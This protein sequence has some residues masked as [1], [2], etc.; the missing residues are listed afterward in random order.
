MNQKRL[1]LKA[2]RLPFQSPN[3]TTATGDFEANTIVTS[4]QESLFGPAAVKA[5]VLANDDRDR[6]G[7]DNLRHSLASFLVRPKTDTKTLQ[8]LLR[9]SHVKTTLQLCAH[10]V[11]EDRLAAQ[12]YSRHPGGSIPPYFV[13][14]D[15]R[16]ESADCI[17]ARFKRPRDAVSGH[18]DEEP[19]PTRKIRH[20]LSVRNSACP[21]ETR[22][23]KLASVSSGFSSV[24]NS[25]SQ[26]PRLPLFA[27]DLLRSRM[28]ELDTIRGVAIL[29]VLFFHGFGFRYGLEGVSGFPRLFVAATLPGWVGVNLFFVLSGFLITG[30]LLDTL[31][32]ANYYRSFYVRR[33]LRILPLYYAVLLLLAVLTRTGWV[34]RH[35]SWAFLGLSFFYLSNVTGL[36]GVPMQYGVLWSLAVEE[37]FYL[38]WPAAVRSLSRHRVAIVGAIICVLCPSLRAFYSIRGYETG[39]GYTW[40]VAD[41]LATGAVLAALA[42]GPWGTRARMRSV[43]LICFA[44]SMTMFTVGYPFGIFRA[45]RFLGVTLRET[46]LNLFFAGTVALALLAGTSRWKAIVNRPVL[47]FFGE[48]SYGV[49]LIHMLVFDLED[50]IVGRLFPSLSAVG[51]HFGLMV[52]LFSIAA[53]CTVAIAY[54]SR[55]YFEER[56]LRLKGRFEGHSTG[57][58]AALGNSYSA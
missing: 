32:K 1:V 55:W 27:S 33:A 34:N 52:L 9:H 2:N 8:T 14:A 46:A 29:L 16:P 3:D 24:T 56:F 7:F 53:G 21:T 6:F 11:S 30:I 15:R 48:I 20:N 25:T 13:R 17:V 37:H 51:G 39:T 36:F 35:A 47:Q 12:G 22:R 50:Y 5:G 19:A 57:S 54:L 42:R 18:A 4:T 28:P 23:C 10:S 26:K 49:Y 45:S 44:A 43:T 58:E 38:L 40:L 41:G 31:P